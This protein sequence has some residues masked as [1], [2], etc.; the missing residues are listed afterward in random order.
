[1]LKKILNRVLY[2]VYAIIKDK[3]RI[4]K[5]ATIVS[6][7]F[8]N[9]SNSVIYDS[10]FDMYWQKAGNTYLQLDAHPVYDFSYKK[11]R[12]RFY[13]MFARKYDLQD[14]DTIIDLGAGI[15]AELP[16]Y[17]EQIG[18]Q[19]KVYAIEASPDSYR[20]LEVFCKLN[21]ISK[22]VLL[23]N[24]AITDKNGCV[25][26][27]ETPLYKANQINDQLQGVEINALTLNDFVIHQKID[28]IDLLKMNIE[29]AETQVIQGMDQVVH[30]VSNFSISCHDFLFKEETQIRKKVKEY[31][32]NNGF[33]I[34]EIDTGNKYID[35][36]VYGTKHK[37]KNS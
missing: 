30:L 10:Q 36:W 13:A 6:K 14:G 16:F 26:I 27:E 19:G 9:F 33:E 35:S 28:K 29:G 25:W 34:E 31:F 5:V 32:G 17:L 37:Y 2:R 21:K 24:L 4:A 18:S 1:M 8:V 3:N 15:G 12:K 11:Y 23:H 7:L 22:Q 20:K